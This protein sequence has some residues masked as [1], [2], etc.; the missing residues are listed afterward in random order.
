[1]LAIDGQSRTKLR[2]PLPLLAYL[3][4]TVVLVLWGLLPSEIETSYTWFGAL[5]QTILVIGLF[6]RSNRCRWLL[7][8][9]GLLTAVGTLMLQT[10]PP[11]FV[12]T[13]WGVIALLTTGLLLTRT[14]RRYTNPPSPGEVAG[15]S[16]SQQARGL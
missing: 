13:A 7:I 16:A 14:M 12:A 15:T 3:A 11:E 10:W 5:L 9:I 8:G 2:S 1:M 6:K 4:G